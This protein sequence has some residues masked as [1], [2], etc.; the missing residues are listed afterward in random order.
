[1]AISGLKVDVFHELDKCLDI[2][3]EV[4]VL[5][6]TV[7]ELEKIINEQKGKHKR[8]AKLALQILKHKEDRSE[9]CIIVEE[10]PDL[11]VDDNLVL[12]SKRGALV[13]TQDKELK[14]RL[15]KPYLTIRQ[16]KKVVVVS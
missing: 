9:I 15:A 16:K 4:F 13:L 1:M 3:Y 12:E 10:K 2:N 8:D 5:S 7:M 6:G 14:S 11:S